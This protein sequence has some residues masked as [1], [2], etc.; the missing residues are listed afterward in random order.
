[1]KY[2]ESDRNQLANCMLLTMDENGARGK[3]DTLPEKWFAGK[4]EKYLDMHLIPRD[5]ALWKLDR[6]EDFITARKALLQEHFK[7]LLVGSSGG[8]EPEVEIDLAKLGLVKEPIK[9]DRRI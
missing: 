7:G 6:F 5:P 4:D 9:L 2:R 1:M 8:K 3:W